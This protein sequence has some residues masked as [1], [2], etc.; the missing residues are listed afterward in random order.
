ME[1]CPT[2]YPLP[3]PKCPVDVKRE[4]GKYVDSPWSNPPDPP[5]LNTS[6]F[7][8]KLTAASSQMTMHGHAKSLIALMQRALKS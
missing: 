2:S 1:S 8:Q 3:P 5:S 6:T 4:S 7:T